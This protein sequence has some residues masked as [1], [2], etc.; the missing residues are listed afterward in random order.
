MI[1]QNKHLGRA[2]ARTRFHFEILISASHWLN[3]ILYGPPLPSS[4]FFCLCCTSCPFLFFFRPS[5][6][7]FS[8]TFSVF[9]CPTSHL[10]YFAVEARIL[11]RRSHRIITHAHFEL[12]PPSR[13]PSNLSPFLLLCPLRRHFGRFPPFRCL[14]LFL[15]P[16][17]LQGFLLRLSLFLSL[18]FA[19]QSSIRAFLSLFYFLSRRTPLRVS[20]NCACR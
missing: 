18:S 4:L 2:R 14:N 15:L 5:P 7:R 3:Y 9:L 10:A 16:W 6:V 12:L 19:S 13:D 1:V 8:S 17:L 20:A 11:K